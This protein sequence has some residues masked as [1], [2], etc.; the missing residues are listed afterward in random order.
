MGKNYHFRPLW[1]G[2]LSKLK[3]NFKILT[4]TLAIGPLYE[5]FKLKC[6]LAIRHVCG[7]KVE[8]IQGY[9]D[10]CSA[11]LLLVSLPLPFPLHLSS[12]PSQSSSY[13][14]PCSWLPTQQD[15]PQYSIILCSY[16][17]GTYTEVEVLLLWSIS[18]ATLEY[19]CNFS[20]RVAVQV[21]HV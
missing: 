3:G 4:N 18:T 8:I 10:G 19:P 11:Y 16:C 20:N 15:N 7:Q 6:V 9:K 12:P 14:C 5:R 17:T 2:T 1:T 21:L 13:Q